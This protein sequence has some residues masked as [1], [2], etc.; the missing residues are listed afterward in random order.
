[1][2]SILVSKLGSVTIY[3]LILLSLQIRVKVIAE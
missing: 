2:K 3:L 1:M